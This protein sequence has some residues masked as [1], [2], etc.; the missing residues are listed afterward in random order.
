METLSVE[1]MAVPLPQDEKGFL[2]A[3]AAGAIDGLLSGKRAAAVGPGLGTA[4]GPRAAVHHL[5]TSSTVPVV[6]DA[7]GLTAIAH[8]P[9]ILK[10]RQ[11]P[12]ILTPHPG[13]MARLSGMSTA[14]VQA[15]RMAAAR[16]FAVAH[17]VVV[18]LKGARTL[19]A[20]PDGTVHLNPTGN[21]G[22]ATGGMGDILA[23]IIAGL[24]AQGLSPMAAAV[25]GVYLHGA[26][27]DAL[28]RTVG[29]VGFLA[30]DLLAELPGQMAALAKDAAL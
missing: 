8:R 23:G 26:A 9:E 11:A 12:I 7:D 24:L 22:M 28:W 17:G 18:V 15:D 27:A 1:G 13:E 29:P 21:P 19:I 3:G 6:V 10:R 5:V 2:A 30:T 16:G 14:Q 25:T 4:D 20:D